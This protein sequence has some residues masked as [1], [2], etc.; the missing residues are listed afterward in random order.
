MGA[1]AAIAAI[2]DAETTPVAHTFTP[3]GPDKDGVQWFEQTAPAAANGLAAKRFS[4]SIKRAVPG[5]QLNGVARITGRFWYP[6]METVATSDSGITPPPTVA[7]QLY[8][9]VRYVIPERSTEQ[10]R[11][12]I[13]AIVTNV[14]FNAIIQDLLFKLQPLY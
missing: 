3:L 10:E 9:E 2:N 5:K 12:N 4:F 7:Y 1:L 14:Q 6:V 13:K 11:K 8:A